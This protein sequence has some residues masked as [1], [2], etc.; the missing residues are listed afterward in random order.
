MAKPSVV[1]VLGGPGSGKGTQSG[2]IV[3]EFGYHHIS[4]GSLLRAER[5]SGSEYGDLIDSCIKD[6]KIVPVAITVGLIEKAMNVSPVKKFV[7]DGFPR[8]KDNLNGWNNQM[9]GK[10]D[11]KFVLFID[12]PDDVCIERLKKRG[13]TSGR[14][15]DNDESIQKRLIVYKRE[16]LPII[17][18]YEE[19]GLLHKVNGCDEVDIVYN[20][21]RQL[22][23]TD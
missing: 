10:A 20:K 12:C 16:T 11:V 18:R 14:K 23:V 21:I 8:N 17:Q 15:D 9:E 3:E 22:F 4:A 6:G 7:V 19:Q 13:Q 5:N 2:K 1:F